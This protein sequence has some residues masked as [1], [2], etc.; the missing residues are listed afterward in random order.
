M[1]RPHLLSLLFLSFSLN[2]SFAIEEVT[3]QVVDQ[4]TIAYKTLCKQNELYSEKALPPDQRIS[5][6]C[7]NNYHHYHSDASRKYYKRGL[8]A[9]G[10][11]KLASFNVWHPGKSN[12]RFKD[13][14]LVARILNRYDIVAAQ[15]LLP[16]V[17]D[18]AGDNE[19]IVSEIQKITENKSLNT[20]MD[21]LVRIYNV[22]GY[23]KILIELR[24]LDPSW[25]L[26]LS[27]RGE[28]QK[29]GDVEELVGFYYRA[30]KVR[31]K[32]NEYCRDMV[33]M[34]KGNPVACT[35]HFSKFDLGYDYKNLFSRRPFM[36]S[37]VS[38]KFDF[39]LLSAHVIFTSPSAGELRKEILQEVFNV[40][41]IEELGS[42]ATAETYA[43]LGEVKMTLDFISMIKKKYREKDIIY[44]GDFNLESNNDAL[45]KIIQGHENAVLLN[46]DLSSVSDI[47]YDSKGEKTDGHASNYDHFILDEKETSECDLNSVK[48]MDFMTD[49]VVDEYIREHYLIRSDELLEGYIYSHNERAKEIVTSRFS[50]LKDELLKKKRIVRSKIVDTH[51]EKSIQSEMKD[52]ASRVFNSQFSDDSYYRVYRELISDHLPIEMSCRN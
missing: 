34:N 20:T 1:K 47:R 14:A 12:S 50:E 11:I 44:T 9:S 30:T 36:G 8:K 37:F 16:T 29:D 2:Y 15:E 38:G 32:V 41:T 4:K 39:T 28:A 26:V 31:P 5:I 10:G 43:R 45:Q 17:G 24:K 13:L 23:F 35:P 49:P 48:A 51:D 52:F 18:E 7:N 46:S 33:T 19:R 22:P 21:E 40:K 3:D 42:G 27:S 6:D 25:A